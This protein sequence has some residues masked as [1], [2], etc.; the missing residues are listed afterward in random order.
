MAESLS[1]KGSSC[2]TE[3]VSL[4]FAVQ[5][6]LDIRKADPLSHYSAVGF[7]AGYRWNVLLPKLGFVAELQPTRGA[8]EV[9]RKSITVR[10]FLMHKAWVAMASRQ[11]PFP[12][13]AMSAAEVAVLEGNEPSM[14]R[15]A[16][17]SPTSVAGAACAGDKVVQ[18]AVTT[19]R[20]TMKIAGLALFALAFAFAF[21]GWPTNLLEDAAT[22]RRVLAALF[23]TGITLV[24]L[25]DVLRL[26]KSA[27]ML[28]LASVMWTYHAAGIHA[29][30]AEGHELLEE[31]L[32]KGLFEVG[33]VILFLLPAMCVVESIDHMN[34]FAVVTAF[35]VR[36]TQE[37][38]GRLMPIVCII[39]FFLSSVIDNLTATIVC[40]KILQRVVPHNQ[41]WRHSCG[42]VVVITQNLYKK[43][44]IGDVTTTM[45]WI[46]HKVSTAGIVT[47]TFVP[48]MVAGF[49]PLFGIWWQARRC[50]PKTEDS[51]AP[52]PCEIVAPSRNS[53]VVLAVGFGCIL[54]VPIVKMVTGLP[55]YLGM[56]MALGTFWLVTEICDLGAEVAA[57]DLEAPEDPEGP[58]HHS[59]KGVPAALHKVDISSLLFFT[60]VLLGV[61]VLEAAQVL[62]RYSKF[63]R[64]VTMDNE[65]FLSA[66]LGASS[67][68]VDN[69]PLVQASIEMFEEPMDNP[70][71]QLVA[72]G[73][74]TGGSMLAVG[75]VAGFKGPGMRRRDPD[76]LG[77]RRIPLVCQAHFSLGC[78]WLHPWVGN[79][80]VA[81]GDL[82]IGVHGLL[83]VPP[84][85][86]SASGKMHVSC[87][88]LFAAT[89]RCER[90]Q[91]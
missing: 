3:R 81:A 27:I 51:G 50:G 54:M 17:P 8:V 49:I 22:H 53:I 16:S 60:G 14:A 23:I 38:A 89:V 15:V 24:A 11:D 36:Q 90:S 77:G 64:E 19:T 41:D 13:R 83:P 69:V 28:V 52:E 6:L 57:R 26:D 45:L 20:R 4:V 85:S 35:I 88:I 66:L 18:G 2:Q 33:S 61:A 87:L 39:A 12:Y 37:K 47:W 72:L 40:I 80:R 32:M 68:V 82:C 67:A 7:S 91:L 86:A 10:I 56:M 42:G 73:A 29:R 63:M 55:P 75:S 1:L 59:R 5:D 30:S 43:H 71:W 76:G 44:M 78:P 65:L 46:Q 70:L 21:F 58:A 74:G 62:S 34:G 48:S 9:F 31:E 84:L 25:E 79:L